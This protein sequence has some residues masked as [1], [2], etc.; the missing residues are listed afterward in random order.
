MACSGENREGKG[1]RHR[2]KGGRSKK[3]GTVLSR[4]VEPATRQR[5]ISPEKCPRGAWFGRASEDKKATVIARSQKGRRR[6]G[7]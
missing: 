2:H 7:E 5:R 6:K 1:R 3:G 4:E